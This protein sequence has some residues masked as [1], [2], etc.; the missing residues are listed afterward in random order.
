VSRG[1]AF[2]DSVVDRYAE[3][4][5]FAGLAFYYRQS[6]A[7]GAVLVAAIGSVMVSYVRARGEALGVEVK[8]GTMQRPER[9]L[10]LGGVV[11]HSPLWEAL[12]PTAH[13]Q[14]LYAPTIVALVLL[15]VS[16]NVTAV[17]RIVHVLR[18]LELPS[19]SQPKPSAAN[20]ALAGLGFRLQAPR[21]RQKLQALVGKPV[22]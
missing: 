6:W 18:Q 17:R 15:G 2:F 12:R 1:G 10:Y 19:A 14:P 22:V 4:S 11:A 5:V 8:V 20:G 21:F 7:L 3:L 9:L 13:G 16:A